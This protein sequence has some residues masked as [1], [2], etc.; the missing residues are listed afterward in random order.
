[1]KRDVTVDKM[2]SAILIVSDDFANQ[3]K[4]EI[5]I[6]TFKILQSLKF[7]KNHILLQLPKATPHSEPAGS[8]VHL[9]QTVV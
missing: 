9:P 8:G 2:G 1:M 7:N 5:H 6:S 3:V 4:I